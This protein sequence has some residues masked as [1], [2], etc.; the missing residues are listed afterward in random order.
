LP[1]ILNILTT[2]QINMKH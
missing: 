1:V 2:E